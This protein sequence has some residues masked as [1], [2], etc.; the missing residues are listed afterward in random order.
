MPPG[1]GGMSC[2]PRRTEPSLRPRRGPEE[3][4][5]VEA[6]KGLIAR[7]AENAILALEQEEKENHGI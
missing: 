5:L 7:I 2:S 3:K 1:S 6:A 4:A